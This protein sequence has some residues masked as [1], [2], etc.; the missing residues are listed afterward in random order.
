MGLIITVASL[1]FGSIYILFLDSPFSYTK[2][3]VL[4][5]I[6]VATTALSLCY[7]SKYQ[8]L[9]C[10]DNK[11]YIYQIFT[12]I[13]RV[14]T[15]IISIILIC[16][17]ESIIYVYMIN[18]LNILLTGVMLKRYE[19]KKYPHITYKGIYDRKLINGTKD[20]F[21]Q[22][23]A[24]TI[25]TS[26]DLVLISVFIGLAASSVY[27]LYCQ[28]FRAIFNLLTA[29]V[30]APFNS[31]GQIAHSSEKDGKLIDIFKI[32]QHTS[33][34]ISTVLLTV[35]GVLILPFVNFYTKNIT[36]YN[37]VVPSLI[38][39]F[40]SQFFFQ[41]VNRPFGNFLNATGN[42]EKQNIQCGIATVVNLVVSMAFIKVWGLNSI[43][44]G[45]CVGTLIILITNV[46][47]VSKMFDNLSFWQ[48]IK[49][50]ILNYIVGIIMIYASLKIYS[51]YNNIL[52]LVETISVCLIVLL[53]NLVFFKDNTKVAI[54]YFVNKVLSKNK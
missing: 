25:F 47:I 49:T 28:V 53:I 4:M 6:C 51:S 41:I 5:A 36:D 13:S 52:I 2:T 15:W 20:V 39:L 44:F 33:I 32:Y 3:F 35:T 26:T 24:N 45:S 8:I 18:I 12:V 34:I 10:A 21:F 40:F 50:I 14:I 48:M 29:V 54:K 23:I 9:L 43:I 42:F 16:R 11:E 38:I 19:M 37:Y 17:K 46:Y 1:C 7:L 31:I 30:Q 22:K 27:N